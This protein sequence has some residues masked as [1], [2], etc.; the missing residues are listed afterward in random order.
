M[1]FIHLSTAADTPPVKPP[2]APLEHLLLNHSLSVLA[3]AVQAQPLSPVVSPLLQDPHLTLLQ[4]QSAS[5]KHFARAR[6]VCFPTEAT[7]RSNQP[8]LAQG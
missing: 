4:L 1:I 8:F 2:L 7:G 3:S 6:A 5:Y